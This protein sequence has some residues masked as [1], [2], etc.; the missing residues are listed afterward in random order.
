MSDIVGGKAIRLVSRG[1]IEEVEFA[2]TFRVPERGYTVTI[3][4]RPGGSPSYECT[5][6]A[7]GRCYHGEAALLLID[8]LRDGAPH[9]ALAWR[10]I[11]A[12]C[13]TDD[14]QPD[15]DDS[16]FTWIPAAVDVI[17]EHGNRATE[18]E[19]PAAVF[20]CADRLD[21][22]YRRV[23]PMVDRAREEWQRG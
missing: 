18:D 7:S 6:P 2:R 16:D 13:G 23:K 20:E 1:G 11:E 4:T 21:A 19:D 15:F 8:K 17:R 22:L 10:L 3:G 5:C 12:L 14:G 9:K